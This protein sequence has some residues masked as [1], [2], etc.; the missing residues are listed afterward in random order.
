M[1]TFKQL[2]LTAVIAGICTTSSMASDTSTANTSSQS[3]ARVTE[4]QVRYGAVTTNFNGMSG[5]ALSPFTSKAIDLDYNLYLNA[6]NAVYFRMNLGEDVSGTRV[7]YTY[8]GAG[9]RYFFD[10]GAKW[11]VFTGAE[12]GI[13]QTEMKTFGSELLA[14]TNAIELGAHFGVGYRISQKISAQVL[15][16]YAYGLGYSEFSTY[17]AHNKATAGLSY[18]F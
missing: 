13:A 12:L 3:P 7:G 17:E 1:K 2:C 16:G 8:A 9:R 5:A 10:T 4:L 18:L 15:L 6:K 14:S 11:R